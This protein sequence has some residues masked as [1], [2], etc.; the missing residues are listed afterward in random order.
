MLIPD[1]ELLPLPKS[2]VVPLPHQ[3]ITPWARPSTSHCPEGSGAHATR[4]LPDKAF[5]VVRK[6]VQMLLLV[7]V[8]GGKKTKCILWLQVGEHS[9]V[10]LD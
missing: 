10:I 8:H 7:V 2:G 1:I 3:A 9:S 4:Y 6:Q 5:W